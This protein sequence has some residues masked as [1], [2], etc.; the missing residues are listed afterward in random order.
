MRCCLGTPA[1]LLTRR[2]ATASAEIATVFLLNKSRLNFGL[3]TLGELS[4]NPRRFLSRVV[5]VGTTKRAG[6]EGKE[7][8]LTRR[9]QCFGQCKFLLVDVHLHRI[10]HGVNVR[11]LTLRS[12]QRAADL[13]GTIVEKFDVSQVPQAGHAL[14]LDQAARCDPR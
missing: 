1:E 13:C 9:I 8:I 11:T 12:F 5:P 3:Q 10:H 7:V 4:Q 2:T 14:G 6:L